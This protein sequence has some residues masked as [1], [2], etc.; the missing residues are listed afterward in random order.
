M[1]VYGGELV[2]IILVYYFFLDY[3]CICLM[4][5]TLIKDQHIQKARSIQESHLFFGVISTNKIK[6]LGEITRR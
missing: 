4:I 2:E 5:L 3:N 1:K 6:I